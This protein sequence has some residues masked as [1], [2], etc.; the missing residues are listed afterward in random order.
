MRAGRFRYASTQPLQVIDHESCGWKRACALQLVA[1]VVRRQPATGRRQQGRVI[2][3]LS[4]QAKKRVPL[5]SAS[6]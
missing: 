5:A 4:T 3:C 1:P 6:R 2:F